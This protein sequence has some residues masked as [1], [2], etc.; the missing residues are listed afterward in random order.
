LVRVAAGAASRTK[1]IDVEGIARG[2]LVAALLA[3]CED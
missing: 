1:L 3:A 2:D